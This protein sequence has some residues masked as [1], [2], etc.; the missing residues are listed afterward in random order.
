MSIPV[1]IFSGKPL[2][3]LCYNTLLMCLPMVHQKAEDWHSASLSPLQCLITCQNHEDKKKSSGT[4]K[5]FFCMLSDVNKK[6]TNL[7]SLWKILNKKFTTIPVDCLFPSDFSGCMFRIMNQVEEPDSLF[8]VPS[9]MRFNRSKNSGLLL[10]HDWMPSIFSSLTL[11][12]FGS[13]QHDHNNAQC[14]G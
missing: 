4:Q 1:I 14:P 10:S 3:F 11:A 5:K 12:G 9:L 13:Q 7:M 2:L 6:K 8:P